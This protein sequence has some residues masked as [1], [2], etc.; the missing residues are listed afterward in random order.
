MQRTLIKVIF[1]GRP[2]DFDKVTIIEAKPNFVTFDD[3][4]MNRHTFS[5]AD[6]YI[7]STYDFN[8]DGEELPFDAIQ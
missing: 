2:H 7:C 5:G 3:K 1:D 6:Y 8:S 4:D